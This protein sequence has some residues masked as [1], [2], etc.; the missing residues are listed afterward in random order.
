MLGRRLRVELRY[1]S[2]IRRERQ[3]ARAR[4]LQRSREPP[5]GKPRDPYVERPYVEKCN[6]DCMSKIECMS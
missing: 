1:S 4:Q 6:Y 5:E 2:S 3:R